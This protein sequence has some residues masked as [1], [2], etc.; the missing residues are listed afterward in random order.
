MV[1]G[2]AVEAGVPFHPTGAGVAL[3]RL[4]QVARTPEGERM[5]R[6][7]EVLKTS[8]EDVKSACELA[9]LQLRAWKTENDPRFLGYAEG[10]LGRWWN[11]PA[12]PAEVR[13]LRAMIRQANHQFEL[14]VA[15][16]NSVVRAEPGNVQAWLT[17]AAVEQAR[18]NLA[19][20]RRAAISLARV[21]PGL[22]SVTA[23]AAIS[24]LQGEAGN[25][26]RILG[27]ALAGG[28]GES[29]EVQVWSWT[30]L[31]EIQAQGGKQVEAEVS[32]KKALDINGKD[33]Y[34]RGALADLL[35]E[36][37]RSAEVR[38]LLAGQERVDS[39]L[40]RLAIAEKG[41]PG[42]KHQ[43][44]RHAAELRRR[45]D[46]AR[47]LNNELHLREEARFALEIEGNPQAA[48]ELA[49]RNWRNQR[50]IADARVYL[51]A[52]AASGVMEAAKEVLDWMRENRMEPV[53][54]LSPGARAAKQTAK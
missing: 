1:I 25:A 20:A 27:A 29:E 31:G 9:R 5:R 49:R 23:A 17:L 47:A 42:E 30:T 38:T 51:Q 11:S 22:I 36:G 37:R 12:V 33:V 4:P 7:G 46:M 19:G 50:E 35:L 43:F 39:L 8:P 48:L 6:L 45:F 14:A 28:G 13:L 52:A 21:A 26:E 24:G 18:G 10:A 2:C 34:A 54:R 53:R 32:F 41:I 15:D 40:L 16:L 44:E 3:E